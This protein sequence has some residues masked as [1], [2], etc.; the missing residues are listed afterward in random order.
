MT[1]ASLEL[2]RTSGI[3][4]CSRRNCVVAEKTEKPFVLR[5]GSVWKRERLSHSSS[6]TKLKERLRDD[7][8]LCLLSGE[9]RVLR[10]GGLRR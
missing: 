7:R 1:S 4:C 2:D 6:S 9:R 10:I 5:N 8:G 3:A